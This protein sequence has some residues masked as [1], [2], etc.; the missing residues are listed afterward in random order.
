MGAIA[1]PLTALSL[2]QHFCIGFCMGFSELM[3]IWFFFLFF[4]LL[5]M[6]RMIVM[7]PV[8]GKQQE[9]SFRDRGGGFY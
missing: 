6:E 5:N 2:F 1:M 7:K 4:S 8:G 3:G 9:L